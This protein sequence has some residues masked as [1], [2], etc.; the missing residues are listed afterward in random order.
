MLAAQSTGRMCS[1]FKRRPGE[2]AMASAPS[3]TIAISTT[4]SSASRAGAIA[5]TLAS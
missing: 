5:S 1:Y 2:L 3:R 4:R